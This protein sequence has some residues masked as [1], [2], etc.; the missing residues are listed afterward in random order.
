[1]VDDSLTNRKLLMRLLCARGFHCESA[2]NGQEAIGVYEAARDAGRPFDAI[3]LD[4]QMPVMNGPTCVKTL[5]A[6]GCTCL[7]VGV[8]KN[9]MQADVDDFEKHGVDGVFSKPLDTVAFE[10][11]LAS[12]YETGRIEQA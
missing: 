1:V 10:S 5:R 3:L 12:F 9:V 8:T 11:L 6:I 4:N 2:E 7:V